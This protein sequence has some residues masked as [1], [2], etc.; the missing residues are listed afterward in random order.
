[1]GKARKLND[2]QQEFIKAQP[3]FF[4]A[5]AA[6]DG[7]VNVSPKGMNTLRIVEN[8]RIIWLNLTG[9]GNETAAHLLDINRMTLMFCAFEG[10]ALI[11]RVYGQA[12]VIHPHDPEWNFALADFPDIAG[13]RQIFDMTID[14]VQ[15]S[16][17][18]GVPI[19]SFVKS[20][21]EEELVPYYQDMGPEA[22][23]NYC[24]RKNSLS[25]DDKP[26]RILDNG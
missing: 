15:T 22:V 21:A 14:L 17:G 25:I 4:V 13:S 7:R 3:L 8:N 9:S 18:T 20:R 19:M 10:D 16:C 12:K 2:T 24:S 5:T 11:L 6:Q 1:M 26:T 23:K